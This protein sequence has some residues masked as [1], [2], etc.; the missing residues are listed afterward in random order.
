[1]KIMNA[2]IEQELRHHSHLKQRQR[3]FFISPALGGVILIA[4]IAV[5]VFGLFRYLNNSS[6]MYIEN[7]NLMA[8]VNGARQLK[9]GGSYANVD[10]AALQ[11]IQ[12]FGSMT[13]SA[14][15]GTVRNSWNGTVVVTGSANQLQIQYN[16]VPESACDGFLARAANSGEFAQPLPTCS[17]S[18]NSDL[19]FVV[20]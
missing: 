18:G 16:G 15:G 5:A 6:V 10:N 7:N 8:M 14:P 1:M 20:Y 11:R 3:G 17:A 4:L 12:A 2:L 9:I 13:G 19:T